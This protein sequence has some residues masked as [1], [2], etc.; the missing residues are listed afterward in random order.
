MSKPIKEIKPLS[1]K[2]AER[3]VKK[4]IETEKSKGGKN[5]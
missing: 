1:G 4:M 3:F 5:G 2:D